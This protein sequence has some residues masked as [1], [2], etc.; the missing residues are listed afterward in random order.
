MIKV[1]LIVMACVEPDY[2][3]CQWLYAAEMY[4]PKICQLRRPMMAMGFQLDLPDGW[5]TFTRCEL[6]NPEKNR[7]RG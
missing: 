1:F 4:N 2:T 3:E 7:R 6:V 5:L